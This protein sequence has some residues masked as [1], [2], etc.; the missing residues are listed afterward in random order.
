MEFP[1]AINT[2][3]TDQPMV[4]LVRWRVVEV[5]NV[6]FEI[7]RHLVGYNVDQH[8]GRVSTVIEHFDPTAS[9][10]VTRSGRVYQLLGPPGY[11]TDAVWVWG[12]WSKVNEMTD[13]KDVTAEVWESIRVAAQESI[14]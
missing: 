6:E 12:Y 2:Y 3:I 11:D 1:S 4:L 8:E 10:V 7:E 5:R 14:K 9:I 13:E